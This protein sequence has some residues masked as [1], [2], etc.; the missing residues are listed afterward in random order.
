LNTGLISGQMEPKE[1]EEELLLQHLTRMRNDASGAFAVHLH[2]SALRSGNRQPR[3][4]GIA[5]RT[6]DEFLSGHDSILFDLY[7][8]DLVLMC[9]NVPIDDVD[10]IVEKVRALFSEDPLAQGEIG[11][12]EDHFSTWHDL[13]QPDDFR[14]LTARIKELEAAAATQFEQD[15]TDFRAKQ[16]AADLGVP[17]APDNLAAIDQTMRGTQ[18]ADII[19]NQPVYHVIPGQKGAIV[20]REYFIAMGEL[21]NRVAPNVNLF[22]SPW[23]F[24]YLTETLDK[25]MLAVMSRRDLGKTPD[26]ISLNLNI[27]TIMSRD[28]QQFHE[29][30]GEHTSQVVVE[31]QIIDIFSD[32]TA[33]HHAH[34]FLRERG[35]KVLVDGLNP[36]AINFFDPSLLQADF[37]K[38]S[39]GPEFVGEEKDEKIEDMRRIVKRAGK[40]G[41]ILS[42]VDSEDAV[43]WGATLGIAR[44]QG[45]F[46]DKLV[47]AVTAKAGAL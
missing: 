1:G 6:F 41:V 27:N 2:L 34:D 28:F 47:A 3:F 16:S 35:Y 33:Y 5:K 25:R 11:S 36:I 20:F 14:S 22:G 17:L 13:S 23:L 46:I 37:L 38:I 30:L 12:Y 40:N 39:W 15:V 29:S 4:L 10:P 45:Y 44:F 26:Q 42:R 21:K 18:I 7:N 8:A 19:R 32:L 24:Q 43:K 31:M 9:R